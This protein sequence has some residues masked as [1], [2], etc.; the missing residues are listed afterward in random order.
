MNHLQS[1]Q[2]YAESCGCDH[3]EEKK[4]KSKVT[5]EEIIKEYGDPTVSK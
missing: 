4:K 2:N 1:F 5:K 3:S